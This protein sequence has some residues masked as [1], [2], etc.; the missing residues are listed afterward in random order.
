MPRLVPM[1]HHLGIVPPA[2]SRFGGSAAGK[3]LFLSFLLA[4][5]ALAQTPSE[6]APGLTLA[7]F[8]RQVAA[9]SEEPSVSRSVLEYRFFQLVDGQVRE[10]AARQSLDRLA[11]WAQAAQARFEAQSAP[12]LDVEMLRFAEA[13]AVARLERWQAERN[14]GLESVN[15]LLGREPRA[16]L[17]A[18]TSDTAPSSA[19]LQSTNSGLAARIERLEQLLTQAQE[20]LAK[21]HQN[22]LFGGVTLPALLWQEEQTYQTELQYRLLLLQADRAGAADD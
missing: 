3:L 11:G 22:Y 12:L 8:R 6:P 9:H 1:R 20:L 21:M 14:L 16:P 17:I 2:S 18:I 13:N 15:R 5:L 10:A 19:D 7:E 4:G